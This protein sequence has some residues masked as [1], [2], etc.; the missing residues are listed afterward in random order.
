MGFKQPMIDDATP[1]STRIGIAGFGMEFGS[2]ARVKPG[3][4]IS[5]FRQAL[6]FDPARA[7]GSRPVE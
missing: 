6:S 3:H 4:C 5:P 7:T 1:H 2:T